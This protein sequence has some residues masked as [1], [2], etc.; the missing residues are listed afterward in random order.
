MPG[1]G[2]E[3]GQLLKRLYAVMQADVSKPAVS[4]AI[5]SSSTNKRLLEYAGLKWAEHR[6]SLALSSLYYRVW[7]LWRR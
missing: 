1:S 7:R 3:E 2:E 5:D 6:G 4:L